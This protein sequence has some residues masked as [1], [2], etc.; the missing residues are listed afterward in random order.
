VSFGTAVA[1]TSTYGESVRW[2]QGREDTMS[3]Q[4]IE[5]GAGHRIGSRWWIAT[6]VVVALI[7]AILF[8]T[9][10]VAGDSG[11]ATVPTGSSGTTQIQ[12]GG[13]RHVVEVPATDLGGGP[14]SFKPLT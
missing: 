8:V 7:V 4:T 2:E 1:T 9:A 6:A 13:A 3:A 12:G 10:A 11:G 5:M 14:A